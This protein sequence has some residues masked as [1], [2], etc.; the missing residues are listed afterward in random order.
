MMQSYSLTNT[1]TLTNSQI[2]FQ[3]ATQ[4]ARQSVPRATL[5]LQEELGP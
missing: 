3:E 2:P 4:T 5:P 1:R